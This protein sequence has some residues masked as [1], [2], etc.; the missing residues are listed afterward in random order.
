LFRA[1]AIPESIRKKAQ[2]DETLA[3]SRK[4]QTAKAKADRAVSR[5]AAA[6]KAAAY[7]VEYAKTDKDL[8]DKRRAAKAAGNFFVEPEA[9]VA[10]VI[11]IRG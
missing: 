6:K 1:R 7:V 4:A 9:K 11:R 5:T 3:K 2:R 10:F 8:V